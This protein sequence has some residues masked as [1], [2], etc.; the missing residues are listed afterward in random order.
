MFLEAYLNGLLQQFD[1]SFCVKQPSRALAWSCPIWIST[2]H[3]EDWRGLLAS[4]PYMT[5]TQ[6]CPSRAY[7]WS[8]WNFSVV[9]LF[10]HL[11]FIGLEE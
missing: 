6:A 11:P 10:A 3:T 4:N 2:F 8:R 7:D 1:L 5:T 9:F